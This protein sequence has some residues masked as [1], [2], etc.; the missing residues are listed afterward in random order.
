MNDAGKDKFFTLCKDFYEGSPNE[1]LIQFLAYFDSIIANSSNDTS[2]TFITTEV[3]GMLHGCNITV[4]ELKEDNGALWYDLN[5]LKNKAR[6]E[7]HE[8]QTQKRKM[9]IIQNSQSLSAQFTFSEPDYVKSYMSLCSTYKELY[10]EKDNKNCSLLKI[11]SEVIK[12]QKES[13]TCIRWRL[14]VILL[15]ERDQKF[16]MHLLTVICILCVFESFDDDYVYFTMRPYFSNSL[17]GRYGSYISWL[18][19]Y[20]NISVTLNSESYSL[21][22]LLRSNIDDDLEKDP[23]RRGIYQFLPHGLSFFCLIHFGMQIV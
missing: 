2:I 4:S 19:N 7:V 10:A 9:D 22:S 14:E 18:S 6:S 8:V 11:L 16:A 17:L 13:L 5:T 21:T 20:N 3:Q 12:K 15:S 1:H 23:I